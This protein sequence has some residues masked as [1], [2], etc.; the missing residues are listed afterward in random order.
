MISRLLP[1][2]LLL[3][4]SSQAQAQTQSTNVFT[5]FTAANTAN[6]GWDVSGP[7]AT[8]NMAGGFKTPSMPPTGATTTLHVPPGMAT[9]RSTGG[10]VEMQGTTKFPMPGGN[11]KAADIN[12]RMA[13]TG[14]TMGK[15]LA[16]FAAKAAFP[17]STGMAI[18]DLWKELGGDIR[19]DEDGDGNNEFYKQTFSNCNTAGTACYEW[20]LLTGT[21]QGYYRNPS[22]AAQ[23]LVGQWH[24]ECGGNVASVS[25]IHVHPTAGFPAYRYSFTCANGQTKGPANLGD[26]STSQ[27]ETTERKVTEQEMIDQISGTQNGGGWPSTSAAPRAVADAIKGGQTVDLEPPTVSGPA[28]VPGPTTT[29]TTNTGQTTNTTT[30]Y[31]ITYQGSTINITN[32][33]STTTTTTTTNPDGSTTTKTETKQ[34]TKEAEQGATDTDLPPLPKLYTPKYPNGISGVYAE[35]IAAIKA[36]PLFQLPTMLAPST[37]G[38]SGGCPQWSV[39]VNVGVRDW[40]VHNASIPCWVWPF[41][42]LVIIIGAL[43]LARKLIFGG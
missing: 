22:T 41:L 10:K 13:P 2:L 37:L 16:K 11:G 15:A 38:D 43:F 34:E 39:H 21:N 19:P 17:L 12:F 6:F 3:L 27:K 5:G 18:Y 28:S 8:G 1:V 26:R 23:Q 25:N 24:S 31:N 14:P 29:T 35:K 9:G 20:R 42:R 4:G 36:T 7:S 40:G 33:T 32:V 30:T